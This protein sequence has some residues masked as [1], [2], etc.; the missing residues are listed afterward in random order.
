VDKISDRVVLEIIALRTHPI[1]IPCCGQRSGLTLTA[2]QALVAPHIASIDALHTASIQGISHIR[3]AAKPQ[4]PALQVIASSGS[5]VLHDFVE[6]CKIRVR[7]A[8]FN[9]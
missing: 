3:Q 4:V 5:P 1:D 9:P 2:R 8:M 6:L 7:V